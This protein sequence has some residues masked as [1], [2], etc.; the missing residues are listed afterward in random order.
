MNAP[1][2]DSKKKSIVEIAKTN[3]GVY[4]TVKG[5]KKL[6][7]LGNFDFHKLV[8]LTKIGPIDSKGL[9]TSRRVVVITSSRL[10]TNIDIN[11]THLAECK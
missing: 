11:N 7:V 8:K 9:K 1:L 6:G 5:N 3:Y 2:D 4:F 10:V